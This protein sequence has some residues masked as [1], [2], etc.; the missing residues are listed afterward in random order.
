MKNLFILFVFA[1]FLNCSDDSIENDCFS[2]ISLSGIINLSNPE[3]IDLQVPGGY[4]TTTVQTRNILI[5]NRATSGYKAFDL[6]CPEG[7]CSSNMTFDGLKIICPC[8]DKEY[9]SLDGSPIN[10]EGCFA[11]E[12]DVLESSNATLQISR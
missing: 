7:D 12:Y 1:F 4:T 2:D 9:N 6:E 3:F 8:S 10:G 11:L 5:I